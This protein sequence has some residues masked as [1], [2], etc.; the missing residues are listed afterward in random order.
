MESWF[1]SLPILPEGALPERDVC[2]ALGIALVTL[3]KH[4]KAGAGPPF[5][6]VMRRYFYR[7]EALRAWLLAQERAPG[8]PA[9]GPG[10]PRKVSA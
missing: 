9:R 2:R 7:P 8:A 5:I 4:R 1:M 3:R 10:R 6:R